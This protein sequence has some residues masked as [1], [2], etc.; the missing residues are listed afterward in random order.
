MI[1]IYIIFK[2]Y[3]FFHLCMQTAFTIP[4]MIEQALVR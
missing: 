2:S 1:Q 4:T 3:E